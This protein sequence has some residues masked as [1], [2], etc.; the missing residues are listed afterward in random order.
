MG[1]RVCRAVAQ[2]KVLDRVVAVPSHESR[3][4]P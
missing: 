1:R 3:C 4:N 2:R